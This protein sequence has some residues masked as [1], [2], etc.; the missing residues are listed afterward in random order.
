MVRR[1]RCVRG[2]GW[3]DE[4]TRMMKP[5]CYWR[6]QSW[7]REQPAGAEQTQADK[8]GVGD[9]HKEV[10]EYRRNRDEDAPRF[11]VLVGRVEHR[12]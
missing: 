12:E 7:A 3:H 1:V 6:Q 5:L 9:S 11:V 2:W 10:D 8:E 4:F